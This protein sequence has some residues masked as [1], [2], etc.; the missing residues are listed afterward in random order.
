VSTRLANTHIK[1]LLRVDDSE[2]T[3]T[4]TAWQ[5]SYELSAG[6]AN[7]ITSIGLFFHTY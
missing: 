1:I 5:R 3:D 7:R 6:A 2:D 4:R